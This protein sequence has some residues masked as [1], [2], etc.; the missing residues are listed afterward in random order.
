MTQNND[1]AKYRVS[2]IIEKVV[3][4]R[5][6][7]DQKKALARFEDMKARQ[8]PVYFA[9]QISVHFSAYMFDDVRTANDFGKNLIEAMGE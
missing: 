9:H 6:Y 4:T 5:W 2:H 7:E 3:Y 1:S 8:I